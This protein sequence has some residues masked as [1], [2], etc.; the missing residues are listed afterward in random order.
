MLTVAGGSLATSA[1]HSV[2]MAASVAVPATHPH[3]YVE[4][5]IESNVPAVNQSLIQSVHR[6]SD[7]TRGDA[8]T[9]M[10][11]SIVGD[12]VRTATWA[13]DAVR[14]PAWLAASKRLDEACTFEDGWSGPDSVAA[15][16]GAVM[17]ARA[18][19]AEL[20]RAFDASLA[21]KVGL[22]SD[23]LPVLSW[24]QGELVGSLSVFD[25]DTYAFYIDRAG[26]KVFS[27]E[28]KLSQPLPDELVAILSV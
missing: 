16:A 25:A 27:E 19:L 14:A 9:A 17:G 5:Y 2:L 3:P 1:F 22:D 24:K 8:G 21:P 7:A 26:R 12:T 20:E 4:F 15:D 10:V 23:G 28:A 11:G 6:V 13:D 18:L